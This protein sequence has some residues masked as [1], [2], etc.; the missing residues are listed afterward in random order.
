MSAV[1]VT[2]DPPVDLAPL[3]TVETGLADTVRLYLQRVS[4]SPAVVLDDRDT[5]G[6]AYCG[7]E[8]LATFWV[9]PLGGAR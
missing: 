8:L 1:L 2:F 5:R 3:T 6:A 7:D 9:A 4:E